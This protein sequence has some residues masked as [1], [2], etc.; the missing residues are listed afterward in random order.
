MLH[1]GLGRILDLRIAA[2][3]HGETAF[4]DRSHIRCL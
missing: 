3:H 2:A 4:T 1:P